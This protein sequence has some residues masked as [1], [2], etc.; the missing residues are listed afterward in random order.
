MFA[1]SDGN[2]NHNNSTPYKK[3]QEGLRSKRRLLFIPAFCSGLR[4]K[5]FCV[6]IE[7]LRSKR[8][9][10]EFYLFWSKE[11]LRSKRSLLELYLFGF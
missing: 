11:G 6:F 2:R 1:I 10:L 8:S 5:G 9:Q 7:R 3:L 4:S